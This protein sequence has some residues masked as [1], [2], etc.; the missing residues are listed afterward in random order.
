MVKLP[1]P[2]N[3]AMHCIFCSL[4]PDVII[5]QNELGITIRDKFPVNPGHTLV[6]PKRH[7]SSY[8]DLSDQEVLALSQLLKRARHALEEQYTP[9]D[10]NI[11]INDGPVAGQTV[12]HVHI[13]LM[14]RYRDDVRDPLGGVRNVIP[15]RAVYKV[16]PK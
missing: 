12:P 14:P 6:I 2:S 15:Q 11:G 3:Y 10:Y 4:P 7:V 9:D 16:L 1:E 5:D 13:H 8:F